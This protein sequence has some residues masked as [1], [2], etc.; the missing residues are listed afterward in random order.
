MNQPGT[1]LPTSLHL[2][3]TYPCPSS[4]MM[5]GEPT[6]RSLLHSQNTHRFGL[7]RQQP[8]LLASTQNK[9]NLSALLTASGGHRSTRPCRP[10]V[11]STVPC[12]TGTRPARS[13]IKSWRNEVGEASANGDEAD[14]NATSNDLPSAPHLEQRGSSFSVTAQA[15]S[16]ESVGDVQHDVPLNTFSK[17]VSNADQRSNVDV[18]VVRQETIKQDQAVT[19][20]QTRQQSQEQKKALADKMV[21]TVHDLICSTWPAACEFDTSSELSSDSESEAAAAAAGLVPL[22]A[23]IK[24][25]LRRSKSSCATLR[26][27]EWYLLRIRRILSDDV[28]SISSSSSDSSE[29][30]LSRLPSDSPLLCPR[31]AFLSA[32]IVAHKF[33][34]DRVYSNRA[35]AKVSGLDVVEIGKGE[36]ALACLLD[37]KLWVGREDSDS[38]SS[39]SGVSHD[40]TS[41]FSAVGQQVPIPQQR[42]REDSLDVVSNVEE[43]TQCSSGQSSPHQP[44]AT[45][46]IL[47]SAPHL[48]PRQAASTFSSTAGSFAFVSP[49][50]WQNPNHHAHHSVVDAASDTASLAA[51]S[52]P[53]L[54]LDGASD[55][56]VGSPH[57]CIATD[58]DGEMPIQLNYE[59]QLSTSP[60]AYSTSLTQTS[61]TNSKK[62]GSPLEEQFTIPTLNLSLEDAHHHYDHHHHSSHNA[63]IMLGKKQKVSIKRAKVTRICELV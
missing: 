39:D 36:L 11:Q 54:S 13:Y 63:H 33:L 25:I 31:R 28:S 58:K 57:S 51:T 27:A 62:R 35:W 10:L 3:N 18:D 8:S 61:Q 22:R 20:N 19:A 55:A 23:F 9:T 14:V 50:Q 53:G 21:D 1:P 43:A 16:Q 42:R 32:L 47:G 24:E 6:Y 29:P 45:P 37:W 34:H 2:P 46:S 56:S 38:A 52:M 40:E 60:Q 5:D 30:D 12:S 41:W 4:R 59:D 26:C 48:A 7:G 17:A 15:S 49:T 44:E